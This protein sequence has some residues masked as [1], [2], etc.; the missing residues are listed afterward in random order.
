MNLRRSLILPILLVAGVLLAACE[1]VPEIKIRYDPQ[2]LHFSG[3]EAFA[4]QTGFAQRFPYRHSGQPN[5]QL[6]TEWLRVEFTRF[7]W[8]CRFDEWQIVNFS[9]P[10]PLGNVVC[11]LP[12]QSSQQILVVAHH[13]QSPATVEGADNDGSGIAILLHLAEIFAVEAPPR[14]TLVFVS[15]D[16]EEYGMIGTKR[17]LETHPDP[18]NIIAGISLDNLGKKWSNGMNMSPIG[19]FRGYGPIWLL[20][21]ARE[22]VRATDELWLPRLKTPLEQLLDQATPISF[23]DQGP[24]VAAGVPAL[25]FATLYPA[26]E[27]IQE[28]VWNTYHTPEDVMAHQ[29][30]AV[31]HQSGRIAEALIRQLLAMDK[32]PQESGPYLYFDGSRQVLRGA[33]LWLIFIAFVLLFF[34]GSFFSRRGLSNPG[35][36]LPVW[37]G[38]LPHFLGLWLPLLASIILLY[39]F[40]A[41]GLMDEYHLYPALAKDPTIF[42]PRWPAVILYLAGLVSFLVAG[43]RLARRYSS[44]SGIPSLA[45]IKSLALLVIGLAGTYILVIN[46][47][48]LLFFVPLLFWFFIGDRRGAGQ[49]LNIGL[50]ALGGLV[51]YALVYYFGFV[52]LR[53]NLAILWYLM[54][55]FSIGMIG[56]PTATAITAI[57]AAGLTMIVTPPSNVHPSSC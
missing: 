40:V 14:Y 5:N 46:P 36:R 21:T 15:T 12:G 3:A 41:A 24:M 1:T 26:D 9:R 49:A 17:Y 51:V 55:M 43:R 38:A 13:D 16:A 37:R 18:T 45:Q 32:F 31:L 33:F 57:L 39:L 56:L 20:L 4:I 48:S 6:A 44:R 35:G 2:A 52:I 53:N 22:A 11:E 54:M 8:K 30:A 34:G 47:F 27:E 7:G 25:G 29:S 28:L 50:F 19:Q 42:Y 23:M 10:V